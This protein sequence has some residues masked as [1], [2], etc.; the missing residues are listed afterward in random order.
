MMPPG[1][2]RGHWREDANSVRSGDNG[3]ETGTGR[4]AGHLAPPASGEEER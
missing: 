2:P 4:A 3:R 1:L